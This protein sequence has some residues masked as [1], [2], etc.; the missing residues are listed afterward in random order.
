M[1]TLPIKTV[2][3]RA[4]TRLRIIEALRGDLTPLVGY[5]DLL[6]RGDITPTEFMEYV[7]HL[8]MRTWKINAHLADLTRLAAEEITHPEIVLFQA[9]DAQDSPSERPTSR[10]PG[11]AI[12]RAVLPLL[13]IAAVVTLMFPGSHPAARVAS[14]LV[15]NN[16]PRSRLVEPVTGRPPNPPALQ[17]KPNESAFR[18]QPNQSASGTQVRQPA[19]LATG[20]PNLPLRFVSSTVLTQEP[21]RQQPPLSPQPPQ[22]PSLN[23]F[24]HVPARTGVLI[25]VRHHHR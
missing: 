21:L 14:E 8:S 23:R 9:P 3:R 6:R 25:T 22:P 4:R 10:W 20:S 11:N 18:T 7:D 15:P 2:V 24:Q 12:R 5:L 16:A 17:I 13:L 1:A 19:F